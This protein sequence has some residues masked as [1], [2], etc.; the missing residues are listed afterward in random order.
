MLGNY[1]ICDALTPLHHLFLSPIELGS[2]LSS[3]VVQEIFRAKRLI[4]FMAR[5][6]SVIERM[7]GM[8][9][10]VAVRHQCTNCYSTHVSRVKL[11][12][13]TA[14]FHIYEWLGHLFRIL[15]GGCRVISYPQNN[16]VTQYTLNIF[17]FLLCNSILAI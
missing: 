14:S 11:P 10:M 12:L 15:N 1:R 7:V 6:K 9:G 3:S 2:F 4:K 5:V 8:S 17:G 16:T 13:N